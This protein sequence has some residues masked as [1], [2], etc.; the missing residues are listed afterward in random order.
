MKFNLSEKRKEIREYVLIHF[1]DS[2]SLGCLD[3]IMG[4]VFSQDAEFIKMLK[5]NMM[6]DLEIPYD[7][8]DYMCDLIDR[9]SGEKFK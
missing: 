5:E 6:K 4:E 7:S 8:S 3:Y 2:I 9:L 1:K